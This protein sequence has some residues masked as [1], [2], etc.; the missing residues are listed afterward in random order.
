MNLIA[1]LFGRHAA[2]AIAYEESKRQ[3]RDPD[4]EIRRVLAGRA[5]VRPEI[6]YYLAAD[7]VPQVR[8]AIAANAGTPGQADLVLSRDGD[9]EVRCELAR[10]IG[11][12]LPG[13]SAEQ[14]SKI[15]DLALETL[16]VLARDQLPRVRA[17]LAEELKHAD[18]VPREIVGRLAR[19][20]ETIVA[21]P[22]LEYSPLLSDGDLLEIISAGTSDGA[23]AAIA[24]RNRIGTS[25]TDAIAGTMVAPA[26]AALLANESAQIREETLDLIIDSAPENEAWHQLLV[27]R[28]ELTVR[29]MR[30]IAGFVAA[31]LVDLLAEKHKLDDGTAADLRKVV[32]RRID[33]VSAVESAIESPERVRD[34]KAAGKLDDETVADAIDRN[35]RAFVLQALAELSGLPTTTIAR[36]VDSKSPKGVT[37]IAWKAGLS[38]RTAVRLQHR[39]AL[40]PPKQVLNARNGVDYPLNASDLEMQLSLVAG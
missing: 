24:R 12:L 38:M 25:V 33:A 36:V 7:D 11:R 16:E 4:S 1:R 2:A 3:A 18:T 40:I 9:D 31:A 10:K 15:R 8:R 28:P 21:A 37:A 34:L 14:A 20:V 6:L 22:V 23:L 29:A 30:R 17:I 19:D 27:L 35:D 5:D 26:V 39:V 32:R 13:L